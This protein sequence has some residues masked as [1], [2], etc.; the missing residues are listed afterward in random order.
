MLSAIF[1]VSVVFCAGGPDPDEKFI[2]GDANMNQGVNIA[3]VIVICHYIMAW[4]GHNEVM[5]P[6]SA[7]ADNDGFIT[8]LDIWYL[9]NFLFNGRE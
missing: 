7:D 1:V 9:I 8:F 3:D 6:D 2:R 5:C 4:S